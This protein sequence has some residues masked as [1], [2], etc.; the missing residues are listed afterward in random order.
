MSKLNGPQKAAIL[1]MAMGEETSAQIMK[2]LTTDEIRQL[3]SNMTYIQ[4][5]KKDVTDEL[6]VEFTDQFKEEADI[7][8]PGDQFFKNLL[9]NVMGN[10]EAKDVIHRI[11]LEKERIPFKY[12]REID[13]RVLANFIKT[14]HPQTIVII[15]VHLGFEKASQ[16]LSYLPEALQNEVVNRV[17]H[18]ETVPADLVREVDEVLQKELLS[19]GQDSQQILGGVQAVAEMLNHSD[20]R[21]GDSILQSLEET[22]SDLAEKVRK[23]MFVFDDLVSINDAG[24]RELMREVK[25]EEL[26]LALKTAS[27][28]LKNKIFRNLSQRAVQILEEELSVMGPVRLSDVEVA[29][30]AI[31]NVARRLEKEGKIVLA[32]RGDGGDS[33]V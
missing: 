3:G 23:L 22:D 28:E 21:T 24:I 19:I 32:G 26:T 20:R 25:N 17:A 6:L 4:G 12:V 31:L 2:N 33:F 27:D 11:E 29:Q 1:L 10:E 13:A 30:Q 18:L 15:L 8:T 9:P 5:V 16:V 7:L 14:E